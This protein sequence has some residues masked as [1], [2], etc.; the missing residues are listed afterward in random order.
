MR[1]MVRR[2]LAAVFWFVA[3]S[4]WYG[5]AAF[6]FGLPE[7]AGPVVAVAV[8]AFVAVDPAHMIWARHTVRN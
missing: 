7:A 4:A 2:A 8:A 3:V 6:A 1:H 5:F